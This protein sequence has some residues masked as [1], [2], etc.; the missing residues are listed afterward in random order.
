[1]RFD[2]SFEVNLQLIA[3]IKSISNLNHLVVIEGFPYDWRRASRSRGLP[4]YPL[5][6]LACHGV[7]CFVVRPPGRGSDDS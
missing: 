3:W 4:I 5:R 6:N 7:V 2:A 1:M